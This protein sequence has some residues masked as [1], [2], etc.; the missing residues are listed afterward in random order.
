MKKKG[1]RL[2][3]LFLAF[4]MAMTI[5]PVNALA[6]ETAD[7]EQFHAQLRGLV[8]DEAYPNGMFEF[9]A[10]RIQVEEG[11]EYVE[12]AIV[13][14]GNTD[15]AASVTFKA[16]DVS[17]RYGKDYY[18][19][20]P[21]LLNDHR[22][23]PDPDSR[24]M[25]EET[26]EQAQSAP[27]TLTDIADEPEPVDQAMPATYE[28]SAG[29]PSGEAEVEA[30]LPDE[31]VPTDEAAPGDVGTDED[32][33]AADEIIDGE[34][35]VD[36][37]DAADTEEIPAEDATDSTEEYNEPEDTNDA[38]D[39]GMPE[40]TA[41]EE[42]NDEENAI[43]EEAVLSAS[44]AAGAD[45]RSARSLLTGTDSDTSLWMEKELA[46]Q[47]DADTRAA[48]ISAY[49]NTYA[50][51]PGAVYTFDFAPGDYKK[52]LRFY[53]IDDDRS[54]DDELVLL[55]L[56]DAVN[57]AL[58]DNPTG[59]VNIVDND[60]YEPSVFAIQEDSVTVAP[61]EDTALVTIRRTAGLEH[62]GEV[63]VSTAAGTAE[64]GE[65]YD[66]FSLDMTFSPGQEYQQAEIPILRH[67]G[68]GEDVF[69]TVRAGGDE[70]RIIIEGSGRKEA[71]ALLMA[72]APMAAS[73]PFT[74][75]VAWDDLCKGSTWRYEVNRG[76]YHYGSYS[77]LDL[78]M[79]GRIS[80]NVKN[81]SSGTW[82]DDTWL[83]FGSKGYYTDF[84]TY[85][86]IGDRAKWEQDRAFASTTR[87]IT[88]DDTDRK[89]NYMQYGTYTW[90]NCHNS[91][92]YF[93]SIR[94]YYLPIKV[95]LC[96][97]GLDQWKE[98]LYTDRKD[99][100]AWLYTRTYTSPASYKENENEATAKYIGGIQFADG[101][102]DWSPASNDG[103]TRERFFYGNDTVRL[104]T[105]F[106]FSQLSEQER[107]NLYPW[108]FK[109]ETKSGCQMDYY[110]V[111]GDNFSIR[112][113]FTGNLDGYYLTSDGTKVYGKVNVNNTRLTDGDYYA[114]NIYPV[115]RQKTAYVRMTIDETK[116]AFATGTFRS[117][118]VVALGMLDKVKYNILGKG[119]YIV[120]GYSLYAQTNGAVAVT[121]DATE[122]SL[123]R[124]SYPKNAN[125]VDT[126]AGADRLST[127]SPY[128]IKAGTLRW[129]DWPVQTSYV[130]EGVTKGE[131]T[132]TP[133]STF[134]SARDEIHLV[135][136]YEQPSVNM[137]VNPA[138][139]FASAQSQAYVAYTDNKGN[140]QTAMFNGVDS[141]RYSRGTSI[142][143]VPFTSGTTYD[144]N[145]VI[146]DPER[147]R[148]LWMD[149]T[150]DTDHD[151]KISAAEK[152]AM[153]KYYDQINQAVF[154]GDI[155]RYT[156]NFMANR[157][158][159]YQVTQRDPNETGLKGQISGWVYHN[160]RT[161]IENTN[162]SAAGKNLP[163]NGVQVVVGGKTA[164]TDAKGY[165][166]LESLDFAPGENYNVSFN[167]GG[168]LFS[169]VA[170][171]NYPVARIVLD[172][173]AVFNVRDFRAYE[174]TN[175][176]VYENVPRWEADA[177]DLLALSNKDSRQL[178]TFRVDEL[179][180]YTV[181]KVEVNRYA[182]DGTLKKTYPAAYEDGVY[183]VNATL[184]ETDDEDSGYY[185]FNPA[186]ENVGAG[187]YLTIKVYDQNNIP[188]AEH[189]VGTKFQKHLSAINLINSF[190]S[191]FNGVIEF[192]GQ[193][194]TAFD[195]GVSAKLDSKLGEYTTVVT[196]LDEVTGVR[197]K[198]ISAGWNKSW[199]DEYDANKAAEEKAKEEAK[200]TE[201]AAT[202][203]A[204]ASDPGQSETAKKLVDT[205]SKESK[206]NEKKSNLI[207]NYNFGIKVAFSLSMKQDPD[208]TRWYFNDFVITGTLSGDS[209]FKY[210]YT[211]PIGVTIF[212][213]GALGGDITAIVA[214]ER[215]RNNKLFFEA[216]GDK[217]D[218]K[219]DL[220][221]IGVS[222]VDRQLSFY[223]MLMVN[224]SI[225][226]GAGAGVGK[227]ASV[228]VNGTADFAMTFTSAN[229]G[230]GK[231]KLSGELSLTLLGGLVEKKWLLGQYQ[232]DLFSYND[233]QVRARALSL[234]ADG[235]DFR[236]EPVTAGD[237]ADRSYLAGQSGWNGYAS[238]A[239]LFRAGGAAAAN[240]HTLMENVYPG[241]YPLIET[242]STDEY[243]MD[244]DQLL[245]WLDDD[246]SGDGYNRAQLKYS[247][248]S[249]AGRAWSAPARVDDDATNDDCPLMY[250][251]GNGK[252]LVVW[253]SADGELNGGMDAV[254]MLNSRNIK[255]RFFD[256]TTRTF[257]PVSHVTRTTGADAVSNDTPC[258]AYCEKDGKEYLMASYV[259]SQYSVSDP[260]EGVVVGDL[261]NPYSTV[262]YRLYD[263]ENDTWADEYAGENAL[264][265]SALSDSQR[266]AFAANWYGQGFVDL[267]RYVSVDESGITE[268]DTDSPYYGQWTDLPDTSAVSLASLSYDPSIL[269][270]ESIGYD[271]YALSAYVVDLD[272]DRSTTEDTDLFLQIYDFAADKF[273]P[274][275][276]L[277][278]D[279]VGQS[280]VELEENGEGGVNLFYIS[281]GNIMEFDATRLLQEGVRMKDRE[282]N[283]VWLLDKRYPA[284]LAPAVVYAAPDDMPVTEFIA[285][286]DGSNVFLTW[287]EKG[288]SYREGVDPASSGA[289]E[290]EN[291]FA[292]HQLYLMM[293]SGEY[294][295]STLTDEDGDTLTY[296]GTDDEG[297]PIDWNTAPDVNGETGRVSAG[298]PIV[299]KGYA[300]GWSQ[301]V[302]LTDEQGANYTDI[303]FVMA[304]GGVLRCVYL[305]G[306]SE[307]MEIDGK[308][309]SAE[310][311]NKRSLMTMDFDLSVSDFT[312]EFSDLSGV[313][314][315]AQGAAVGI[316]IKNESV[317][318]MEDLVLRLYQVDD[319]QRTL[320]D[321]AD[322]ALLGGGASD[323]ATF[324]WD[325]PSAIDG[326]GLVA[327]LEEGGLEDWS[328]E[329]TFAYQDD[330]TVTAASAVLTGRNTARVT[331]TV[332][333]SGAEQTEEAV[334]AAQAGGAVTASAPF[335]I[336]A[337]EEKTLEWS[338]ALP[339][340]AFAAETGE[341]G[342][343]TE[344]AI[345]R[346]AGMSNAVEATVQ[347][348]ADA[349]TVAAA[350]HIAGVTLKDLDT[351]K[352]LGSSITL[353]PGGLLGLDYD[354][355]LAED[356]P[357]A[358]AVRFE[359]SDPSVV[360]ITNGVLQA[361]G[362]GTAVVTA[363]VGPDVSG[364]TYGEGTE[365]LWA[366]NT[367]ALP[368]S[369]LK[370]QSLTVTVASSGGNSNG[371]TST[372]S[373]PA[374]G[375]NSII[376]LKPGA[377]L[378]N[379]AAAV[380]V[381]EKELT[382]AVNKVIEKNGTEIVI[383][384]A[385]DQKAT[386]VQVELPA[387]PVA[388]LAGKTGASLTIQTAI[389]SVTL[390]NSALAA[391]DAKEGMVINIAR[392][393]DGTVSITVQADGKTLDKTDGGLHVTIPVNGVSETTVLVLGDADGTETPLPTSISTGNGIAA[394]LPGSAAVRV[395]EN[396]KAFQDMSDSA[397]YSG[398]VNFVSA[399]GIMN[400]IGGGNFEPNGT[401]TRGMVAQV[402]YNF[403]FK[404]DSGF[405]AFSDV[406]EKDW[407]AEAVNWAAAQDIVSGYGGGRFGG[408]D[409]V[410]REQLVTILHR[411]ARMSG[412]VRDVSGNL[413]NFTDGNRT[414]VWA[415]EA[416]EW[417]VSCGLQEG[418]GNGVLDPDGTATRAEVAQVLK[419]FCYYL[420]E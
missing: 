288:I 198:T 367:D 283:D 384:P 378:E 106:V 156:P 207:A 401:V 81:T 52:V 364:Y 357:L 182:M 386:S 391:L 125:K 39:A 360:T 254:E 369:L 240:E 281:G 118:D 238:G 200:K 217:E 36:E 348:Y 76:T 26:V 134:S 296:P 225:K 388:A 216:A 362:T 111:E 248:Y 135:A 145:A 20:V 291:Y 45:L 193:A 24:S 312:L 276:R 139:T 152:L 94:S 329:H 4:C 211:T 63:T 365:L 336:Q 204:P 252:I 41:E 262:A 166:L 130:P 61:D 28:D 127:Y 59:L 203:P 368:S 344:S 379:G 300:Y 58:S 397:W 393:E 48:L 54:E 297:N 320:L 328:V 124:E 183:V 205:K 201:G 68:S 275:I 144:F 416:M 51:V 133:A 195:L 109:I 351:G 21:R 184:N 246:G 136:R 263:F 411:Y 292:E 40:D 223:G 50:S 164:Y 382:D 7:E 324:L 358:A 194:D 210:S 403:E 230:A 141:N 13:R 199:K 213:T 356:A 142:S 234:F 117:N 65:Y 220:T 148:M 44:S 372:P 147:Y 239:R 355:V 380:T 286:S 334:L 285:V 261:L 206:E 374:E 251:L 119:S 186:A 137:T 112:N 373:L 267:S 305:K 158:L 389:A 399:R 170:A 19:T 151:G 407:Y 385:I 280:Y 303:D 80:F 180:T 100:D 307:I 402:L 9:L 313:V 212:I 347:R 43:Q 343:I 107:K 104:A 335:T 345:I 342:S 33:S 282:G 319:G 77:G 187:D 5:L 192:L 420:V 269:E 16:V 233:G 392:A 346:V 241:A 331:A 404:P 168:Q 1:K 272:G 140:T 86:Q 264:R 338:V 93:S 25:V 247:I 258:F 314:S 163:L 102:E 255:A 97:S 366:D 17:A 132:V 15:A 71:P 172:E 23:E 349:F 308:R 176:A 138:A 317:L 90:G 12:F 91:D 177:L 30:E 232:Y 244:S 169:S 400:G 35:P 95:R 287:P 98:S 116:S 175:K 27:V 79:L 62:Y 268:T 29:G 115:Y 405:P 289:T 227:V 60:G 55:V 128:D 108:G 103:R 363:A 120:Q 153:G 353:A 99:R 398:A 18:I 253:S 3:A 260:G 315:G 218:P 316:G 189:Q 243:G 306:M 131:I 290:P 113:L 114:Y 259:K 72:A 245:V 419:K 410:T 66:A 236:Y 340:N 69:F 231:V 333:N 277:T 273:Y 73:D 418:K 178:F 49:A 82:Y 409:T 354:G 53:V 339:E 149:M 341:D 387:A 417:A 215:Y 228:E 221:K 202:T 88:L 376:T 47:P 235:T 361:V 157:Q 42:P 121:S 371:G 413:D 321:S 129:S 83:F 143:I 284:Y 85:F 271:G 167:Y 266:E 222:A 32:T 274:A 146:T 67:P 31:A 390:P 265:L 256:T 84:R 159:Y 154:S 179:S 414:S 37:A 375:E 304:R 298:D 226:L 56:T 337:G 188:Y 185:S 101:G 2:A 318:K 208:S 165:F 327:T 155:F 173:Y 352:A 96:D 293:K 10:P 34:Q 332:V 257:G 250:S 310:N 171:V 370:T 279:G 299:V 74:A 406:T 311:Q 350:Q 14:A 64:A 408:D 162:G 415:Q 6:A 174:V 11:L 219:I 89:Q 70:I 92:A 214:V 181:G 224:P 383:A 46:G 57:A 229:T 249:S 191:P 196:T 294:F 394:R 270:T 209:S 8:D 126:A 325:V 122:R 359:S 381:T 309:I 295:E 237:T 110:Y 105:D 395:K 278:S 160:T 412:L 301:P 322:I 22:L 396:A 123:Y 326:V 302:T 161:V 323:T 197:T 38:E 377:T 190:E 150:G 75:R 242:I 330:L 87:T 78:S